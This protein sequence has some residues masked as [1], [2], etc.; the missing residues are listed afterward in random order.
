M[1]KGTLLLEG[2]RVSH[3]TQIVLLFVS[4]SP[5]ILNAGQPPKKK[6]RPDMHPDARAILE[7]FYK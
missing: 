6:N 5:Q 2:L 1:S 7:A 3:L 4:S